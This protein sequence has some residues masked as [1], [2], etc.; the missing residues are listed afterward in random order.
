MIPVQNQGSRP[1][2]SLQVYIGFQSEIK[3]LLELGKTL[4]PDG[5]GLRRPMCYDT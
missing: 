5:V 2:F 4:N 3:S 1:G